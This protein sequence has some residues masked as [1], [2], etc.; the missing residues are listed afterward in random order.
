M[1]N[2]T[3]FYQEHVPY[4]LVDTQRNNNSPKNVRQILANFKN[5][6]TVKA[7]IHKR[8]EIAIL[9]YSA[10]YPISALILRYNYVNN[11]CQH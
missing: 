7:P 6:G 8:K 3:K 4:F 2:V 10:A 9:G 1:E 11:F 5:Y